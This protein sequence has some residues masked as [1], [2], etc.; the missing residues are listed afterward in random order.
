MVK[1]KRGRFYFFFAKKIEPSPFCFHN[2]P[3]FML[4]NVAEG[5]EPILNLLLIFFAECIF[6]IPFL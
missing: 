4:I 6:G 5:F 1:T 3:L 2:R